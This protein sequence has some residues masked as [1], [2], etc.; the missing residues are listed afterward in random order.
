ML[1]IYLFHKENLTSEKFPFFNLCLHNGYFSLKLKV[2]NF[3]QTCRGQKFDAYVN[4][5]CKDCLIE[6]KFNTSVLLILPKFLAWNLNVD[7]L[8]IS[9]SSSFGAA[10][11]NLKE[12]FKTE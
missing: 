2:L 1:I 8:K 4:I 12:L 7:I 6:C 9:A 10:S 11:V 5:F 3:R